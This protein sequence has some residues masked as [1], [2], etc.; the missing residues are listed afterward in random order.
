MTQY[1]NEGVTERSVP[2]ITSRAVVGGAIAALAVTLILFSVGSGLGF[3]AASPWGDVGRTAEKLGV[4]AAIWVVVVQWIASAAG[5]YLSGRLRTRWYGVPAHESHFRDTAQGFL[6]WALATLVVA[7]VGA[8]LAEGAPSASA[9]AASKAAAAIAYD[10]DMLF[11]TPTGDQNAIAPAKAEA[12]R[13]LTAG[14]L[15]GGPSAADHD[16]LVASV[17]ARAGVS[18]ADATQRVD[19][20]IASERQAA[21]DAAAAAD[22]ARHAA[23]SLSFL[24][25]LAMLVGAF[26]ASVAGA[27]GGLERDKH[28]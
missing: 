9:A 11:R 7:F 8:A 3:A 12:F 23:A 21:A 13:L 6:A 19:A 20:V 18:P 15:H 26:I 24:T 17:S 22:K 2:A 4:A 14:A 27:L 1:E 10:T 25:A 16:Y 5:G 28:A